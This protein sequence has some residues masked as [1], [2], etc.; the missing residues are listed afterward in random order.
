M[1][2]SLDRALEDLAVQKI[3]DVGDAFYDQLVGRMS[4]RTGGMV[5]S[6]VIGTPEVSGS[7]VSIHVGVEA[8]YAQYQNEGTGVFGPSGARI[9]GNP[10]LAFD[11]PAAGGLVIVHSTAGSPG[12]HFWDDTIAAWPSIVASAA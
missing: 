11:W 2:V 10:L 3:T 4:R 9:Q 7:Q 12:T 5:D 8:D 6:V 1:L